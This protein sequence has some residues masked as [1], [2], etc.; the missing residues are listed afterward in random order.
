MAAQPARHLHVIDRET[1][2]TFDECPTCATK[3]IEL[4]G[5]Q[6]DMDQAL[7][8]TQARQGTGSPRGRAMAPSCSRVP[9][10]AAG[11]RPHALHLQC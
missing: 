9:G 3:E 4:K 5:L 7:R 8:R 6:R 10:V 2:E 1:G 11:D